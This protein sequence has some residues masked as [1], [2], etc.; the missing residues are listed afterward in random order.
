MRLP[1]SLWSP[2]MTYYYL[3][4]KIA[5]SSKEGFDKSNPYIKKMRLSRRFAPQNDRE[6]G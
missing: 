2:A 4:Y 5:S 3:G 1:C 6:K